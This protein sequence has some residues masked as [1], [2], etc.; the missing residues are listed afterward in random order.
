MSVETAAKNLINYRTE[1]GKE[2]FREWLKALRDKVTAARVQSRLERVKLG[3]F[4][5]TKPVGSGVS[6]LRFTFGSGFRVYFGQDGDQIVVLLIGGDKST[7]EKDLQ[8]AHSYWANYTRRT[9]NG[10]SE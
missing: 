2:P 9:Q 10:K 4:G 1:D 7:Q 5:D 6:D 3:N 8:L